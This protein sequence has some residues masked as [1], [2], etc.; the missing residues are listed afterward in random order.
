M[1][2]EEMIGLNHVI[3]KVAKESMLSRKDF[4]ETTTEGLFQDINSMV[5]VFVD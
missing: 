1:R 5:Q 2:V 3:L 4:F